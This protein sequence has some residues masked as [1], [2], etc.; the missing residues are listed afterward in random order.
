MQKLKNLLLIKLIRHLSITADNFRV[1]MTI[2]N[3]RYE[4][5]RTCVNKLLRLIFDMP[6]IVDAS[7]KTIQKIINTTNEII[8]IECIENQHRQLGSDRDFFH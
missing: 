6:K 2:L 5:K 7:S 3:D 4:N 8:L 1:A